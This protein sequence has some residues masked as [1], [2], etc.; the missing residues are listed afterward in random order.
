MNVKDYYRLP[1]NHDGCSFCGLGHLLSGNGYMDVKWIYFNS[2]A[3]RMAEILRPNESGE[4][5]YMDLSQF[6]WTNRGDEVW[7]SG[8]RGNIMVEKSGPKGAVIWIRVW[9]RSGSWNRITQRTKHKCHAAAMSAMLV[10]GVRVIIPPAKE[11]TKNWIQA[12]ERG[13]LQYQTDEYLNVHRVSATV[14]EIPVN[15]LTVK[16]LKR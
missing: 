7:R 2:A 9:R 13:A 12:N 4:R 3:I 15:A 16:R 1:S 10:S 11:N 14:A 5:K 6:G 8:Q